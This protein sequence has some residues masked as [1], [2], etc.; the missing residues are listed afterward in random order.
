M[1]E[2]KA[3]IDVMAAFFYHRKVRPMIENAPRGCA[4]RAEEDG[5]CRSR[6]PARESGLPDSLFY[7][8]KVRPMEQKFSG[9]NAQ[10]EVGLFT[11]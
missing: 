1:A 7:H 5:C 4:L 2:E 11:K 9:Q 6:A 10:H 8:R 3:A